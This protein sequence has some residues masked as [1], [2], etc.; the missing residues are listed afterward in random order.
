[1]YLNI[2]KMID[3]AGSVFKALKYAVS[4]TSKKGVRI[5]NLDFAQRC[6][7]SPDNF[8]F[9]LNILLDFVNEGTINY[10]NAFSSVDL[11]S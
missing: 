2:A 9:S 7:I 1:M 4:V 3:S 6:E 8:H 5:T 11:I 10:C